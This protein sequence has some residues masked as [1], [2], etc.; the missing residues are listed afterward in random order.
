MLSKEAAVTCYTAGDVIKL[1]LQLGREGAHNAVDLVQILH[2]R[3]PNHCLY[4]AHA[5]G[6][7]GL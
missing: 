6:D 4:P 7:A 1:D 2:R 3:R 5:R